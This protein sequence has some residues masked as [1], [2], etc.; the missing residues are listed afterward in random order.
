MRSTSR[1]RPHR[2]SW[3]SQAME[4]VVLRHLKG[5][6][7]SQLEEFPLEQFGELTI[8]RDPSAGIRFDPDKD[9]LVGRQHA[10]IVRDLKDPYRFTLTDLNSRNGTFLN[11]LRVVGDRPL[12]P[13]DVIQLGAG[14]PELQFDID[15]LP[16]MYVKATRLDGPVASV[17]ETRIGGSGAA[18]SMAGGSGNAP[19]APNGIGKATVE[20][21][22]GET[23]NQGRRN[24]FA[25]LGVA[26]ALILGVVGFNQ[27]QAARTDE[28]ADADR[29][30]LDSLGKA[31]GRAGELSKQMQPAEIAAAHS[32]AVVQVDFSWK[33]THRGSGG[34][35]YHRL[36][37]N[38]I[39]MRDGSRRPIVDNGRQMVPAYVQVQ[40]G[41]EPALTLDANSGEPIGVSSRGSGFVVTS[42]G[43][44]ITN[45]HVAYNWQTWYRF[46]A[47]DVGPIID[48]RTGLP[49]MD[50][51]GNAVVTRPPGQW[52]PSETKQAGPKGDIGDFQARVEYL[53]VRFPKDPTPFEASNVRPS[54]R[55]DVALI[56]VD[57]PQ[58]LSYVTME[59][60]YDATRQGDAVTVMGYPG[61]SEEVITVIKSR[62]MFNREAQQRI[63]PDPTL[64]TGN[65]GKILRAADAEVRDGFMTYA[66]SGDTYQLTINSTGGGNSGGPMFDAFGRVIGIYFAGKTT[67]AQVSFSIPIR[68]A[69]E[70]L[71]IGDPTASR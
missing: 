67:D 45:R 44:I 7:A 28:R 26:A 70:L 40:S 14:G 31:Q 60:T 50:E 10:R 49:M 47:N 35:V 46:D 68:Y 71:K 1:C 8:G 59:D 6:K 16:A 2:L 24:M 11:K 62:D 57:A 13:G 53:Y 20:R 55:H 12:Q 34:Q 5:S 39:K 9:D 54:Q 17:A 21:M 48:S 42:N 19:G 37:P 29:A 22:I 52:I 36:V 61:V 4:R 18:P 58:S 38:V 15:P 43:F 3:R 27:I 63:L 69:M 32:G 25:V 65:I 23:R 64:S 41:V 30:R 66:P 56:K 33:L 51:G